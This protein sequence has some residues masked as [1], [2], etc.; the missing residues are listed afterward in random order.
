MHTIKCHRMP[1]QISGLRAGICDVKVRAGHHSC[2]GTCKA[3][4]ETSSV[5]SDASRCR[6]CRRRSDHAPYFKPID[7]KT[8]ATRRC[9]PTQHP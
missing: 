3:S 7:L 8:M 2:T 9:T 4:Q 6:S 5:T 1:S